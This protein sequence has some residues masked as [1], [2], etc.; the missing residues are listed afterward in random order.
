VS[1]A[2]ALI[3]GSMMKNARLPSQYASAAAHTPLS[4]MPGIT[5]RLKISTLSSGW[6]RSKTLR[7]SSGVVSVPAWWVSASS[8]DSVVVGVGAATPHVAGYMPPVWGSTLTSS[9]PA[10]WLAMNL[11]SLI[12]DGSPV[13]S[14]TLV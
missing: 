3:G 10:S 9:E 7:K 2:D 14:L 8:S 4:V 1:S 11:A 12:S 13:I 6:S 5:S